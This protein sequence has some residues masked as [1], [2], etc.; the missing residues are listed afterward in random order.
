MPNHV[1]LIG[2]GFS[3]NWN[4]PLAS[5]VANSLL[6][7]VGRDPYLQPLLRKHGKN[8]EN[9]LSE[10]QREFI[11]SPNSEEARARLN[12]VQGAIGTMFTR[13][14][15]V[16][17]RN[18]D[19]NFS[20]EVQYSVRGF[21]T[22]FDAL[23]SLNQD[24]LL[25]LQYQDHV[26]LCSNTRWNGLQMPG[27]VPIHDP[28]ITGIGD[29]H[30]RQWKPT[31]PPFT[32][33]PRLQPCFKLH[34]SSNWR[35]DDGRN[36]LVIGGN[37]DFMIREHAVLTW[38]YDQFRSYLARPD[39]RLMVIG[40]S[41]SDQHI[42]DVIVEAWRNGTLQGMFLV[43][44]AGRAVLNPTRGLPLPLPN[45]LEDVPSLGGS[46]RTLDRIFGGDAFAHQ[47]FMRFF[48]P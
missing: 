29:K 4:A 25:E 43:D 10:V 47:E 2:A 48:V 41:F 18:T 30:R 35:T 9:A 15:Q 34:G 24:L 40:Y 37:K 21:L 13:L 16:F 1:L 6:Q 8:F 38:Y 39:T 28:S 5:E 17:E 31:T 23:F 26:L 27:M 11:A 44:P 42:N 22:R 14:N 45:D 19:L 7:E 46:T 20:N 33:Q 32:V 36:L 12:T 3:H